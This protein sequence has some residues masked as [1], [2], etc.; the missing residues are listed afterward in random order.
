M[1]KFR[2]C[3]PVTLTMLSAWGWSDDTAITGISGAIQPMKSHPSVVLRSQVIKIKL[4]PKYADVDCTFVLHNTGKATSVLIGFPESGGG[5]IVVPKMGFEY[6][7]SYVDGKRVQVRVQE[8]RRDAHPGGY[9][10]WYLKRVRFGAGQTRVIRNVYRAPL[11]A[12]STGHNFFDYI[13]ETVEQLPRVGHPVPAKTVGVQRIAS[14]E[15]EMLDS[16]SGRSL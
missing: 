6:F 9:F 7:R 13:L 15:V 12:I 11:G 2:L 16:L 5:D 10:R 14:E 8:Q 1:N 4:S 3:V